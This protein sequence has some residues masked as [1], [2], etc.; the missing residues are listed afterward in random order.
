MTD[1]SIV[2]I[3][4]D[5]MV[6]ATQLAAPFLLVVLAIGVLVGLGQSVTQLQEPT[7]TFVPKFV[8]AGVV[9]I[10]AGHWMLDRAVAFTHQLLASLPSLLG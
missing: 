2:E 3:G 7:L 6:L 4:V 5:A 1:N 9:L 8:G 10:V